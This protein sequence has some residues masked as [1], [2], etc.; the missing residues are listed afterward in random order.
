[1]IRFNRVFSIMASLFAA[2]L[3]V[4]CSEATGPE[5]PQFARG[6]PEV[7]REVFTRCTRQPYA[8]AAA[9]IGPHGGIIRAGRH[10]LYVP[11][12]ALTEAA[13]ITMES[14]SGSLNRVSFGPD[15]L[16]FNPH[17]PAHLVMSY[18]N[19]DANPEAGQVVAQVNESLNILEVTASDDNQAAR[20]V[21]AKLFH[22]SD[23]V[24]LS[25]YAVVY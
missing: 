24:L 20:T 3:F 22:F 6:R 17:R 11:A 12:G 23:Y 13:F 8:K 7:E 10:V 5:D 2:T 4:A 16:T 18:Q 25:T 9:W 14:P 19:C 1:M 15:G 21:D